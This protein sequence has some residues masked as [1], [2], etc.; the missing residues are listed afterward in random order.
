MNTNQRGLVVLFLLMSFAILGCGL[1]QSFSPT[2]TPMPTSTSTPIPVPTNTPTL[3][4]DPKVLTL[5]ATDS[6]L[7][8]LDSWDGKY[9]IFVNEDTTIKTL[10]DLNGKNIFCD[11]YS[12]GME[13]SISDM[14]AFTKA[15]GVQMQIGLGNNMPQF[16]DQMA[17]D[18][19]M[20][21]FIPKAEAESNALQDNPNLKI[22]LFK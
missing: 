14:A 13:T 20:L 5:D 4:P 8:L 7:A 17:G 3:T 21:G 16:F 19:N 11:M 6:L 10:E 1:V 2:P 22:V 12:F 18:R 15:A 9:V